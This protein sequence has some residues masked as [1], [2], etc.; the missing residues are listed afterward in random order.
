MGTV[1]TDALNTT[2]SYAAYSAGTKY[3]EKAD[4][5]AANGSGVNTDTTLTDAQKLM[6]AGERTWVFIKAG[7][8]IA[9]GDLV[10]R[11][12]E[13]DAYTGIKSA[14]GEVSK[15]EFLGVADHAIA[16]GYYGWVI[17]HGAC[18]V[19]A[20]AAVDAGEALSSDGDTT[21]GE[22][23]ILT[24]G[25]AGVAATAVVAAADI[26]LA[27]LGIAL[28]SEGS[29]ATFGSGYVIARIDIPA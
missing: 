5:V 14:I 8:A 26:G 7:A 28:E 29:G 15:F 16:S 4:E 22:V 10:Q 25:G 2:Y 6:L 24:G 13:T 21:A 3:V 17:C 19:Q 12:A 27:C 18:V 23:S 20:A 1:R 9:A 11:T